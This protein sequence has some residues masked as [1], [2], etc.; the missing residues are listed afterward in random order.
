MLNKFEI[1]IVK[2]VNGDI[3]HLN[4]MSL[5]ASQS[6]VKIIEGINKI[7]EAENDPFIKVRLVEGCVGVEIDAPTIKM[8]KIQDEVKKVLNKESRNTPY[9]EALREIQTVF[10]AN[11]ITY[12]DKI[13]SGDATIELV[14]QLKAIADIRAPKQMSDKE[15]IGIEFFKGKLFENGGK[16]PNIHIESIG[17]RYKIN[18]TNES[19]ARR[20]RNELYQEVRVS[21]WVTKTPDKKFVYTFCDY[22]KEDDKITFQELKDTV[23]Y[24]ITGSGTE[25]LEK[26]HDIFYEFIANER[27]ESARLFIKTFCH[28]RI[29]NNILRTLL[30]VTKG[31]KERT[32]FKDLVQEI[33]AILFKKTKKL[34]S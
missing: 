24:I 10:K 20:V 22:Y 19:Q 11:G 34:I 7:I 32:E 27:F 15:Y 6:L 16:K 14:A 2:E 3:V 23:G 4:E 9:I 31:M 17:E 12:G 5:Q 25:S 8:N 28:E 30:L 1:K 21:A 29:D 18:C 26:I 33:T 13:F